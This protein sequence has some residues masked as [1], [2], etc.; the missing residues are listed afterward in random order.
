MKS[1]RRR[2]PFR[3]GDGTAARR[4]EVSGAVRPE[5]RRV[6]GV[7]RVP[8]VDAALAEPADAVAAARRDAPAHV[9]ELLPGRRHGRPGALEQVGDVGEVVGLAVH[10]DL[11]QRTGSERVAEAPR[12]AVGGDDRIEEVVEI[13][14]RSGLA[15]EV[16]ERLDEAPGQV[17]PQ[18][19]RAG[20]VDVGG[21]VAGEVVV[22]VV[23]VVDVARQD[24]DLQAMA[25]RA[26][27]LVAVPLDARYEG[28]GI[29]GEVADG[30]HGV[31]HLT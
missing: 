16:V 8:D 21:L 10:R 7:H 29:G 2:H 3:R 15:G 30:G 11:E 26:L 23:G 1:L 27:E 9:E 24:V 31:E 6:A 18:Q 13:P 5:L 19:H 20:H 28:V 14:G 17:L 22:D 4:V 12:P 25:A